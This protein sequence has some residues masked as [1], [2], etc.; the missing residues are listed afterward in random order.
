MQVD[1]TSFGGTSDPTYRV[2]STGHPFVTGVWPGDY[3]LFTAT[4]GKEYPAGT[5]LHI[6]FLTRVSGTGQKY[7]TL[8]YW[9]GEAWQPT[10]ELQT[11]TET[12]KSVQYNFIEQ[13]SNVTV[14]KTFTLAKACT[15]MQFRMVCMANW[16]AGNKELTSPNGGT[17]RLASDASDLDGTSP[18]FEVV[19]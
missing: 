6:S 1:K 12:G 3:W 15:Q 14:D 4:D 13:K 19:E 10:D 2:G 8:E 18:V 7:W 11:E 17:C 16:T 9:D 5:K